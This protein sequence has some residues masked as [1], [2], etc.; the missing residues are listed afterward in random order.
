M[1][2][3]SC[4][5]IA[6]LWTIAVLRYVANEKQ[7]I[8]AMSNYSTAMFRGAITNIATAFC[9]IVITTARRRNLY[10]RHERTA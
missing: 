8:Q 5:G 6:D 1:F 2:P 4:S 3:S 7:L 9:T 10:L